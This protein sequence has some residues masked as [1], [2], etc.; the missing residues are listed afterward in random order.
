[1]R[2]TWHVATVFWKTNSGC[3]LDELG[4]DWRQKPVGRLPRVIEGTLCGMPPFFPET[5]RVNIS[6]FLKIF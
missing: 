4:G 2:K 1:M 6:I 5:V 3:A